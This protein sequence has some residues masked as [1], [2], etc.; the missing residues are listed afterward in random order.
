MNTELEI[1]VNR[2]LACNSFIRT[3]VFR[4]VQRLASNHALPHFRFH[5]LIRAFFLEIIK[6][7]HPSSTYL[8]PSFHHPSYLIKIFPIRQFLLNTSSSQ[9]DFFSLLN[10]NNFP[11]F[12]IILNILF[13]NVPP[14]PY[15]FSFTSTRKITTLL[16]H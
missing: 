3:S 15:C 8:S 13:L 2:F 12:S 10:F 16:F 1:S 9:L 14:L 5:F 7:C 6:N 11:L 4:R